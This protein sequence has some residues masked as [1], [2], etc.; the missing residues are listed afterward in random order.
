MKFFIR[1]LFFTLGLVVMT[2]GVCMTIKVADIGVGAWDALNVAL[3]KKVGLSVGKWVMIDGAILVVV[4][5][6]LVKRRPAILSLF[7]IIVI[8]SLVDFWLMTFFQLFEVH[9][10]VAKIAMLLVGIL[11]IGF[12]A[13]IYIQAKFPQSP[14][15]NF[16]LAIKERFRVNLMMAKTIGEITALIPAFLLHGPISYGTIIITFTVGPAIQLFFP[17]FEKLMQ[18]LQEKY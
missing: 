14:I 11:I 7:T 3:T 6:L 12:G 15:D 10:L 18:R 17:T 5:S 13:A 2:F 9:G 1:L 8:G 4:N 16:M